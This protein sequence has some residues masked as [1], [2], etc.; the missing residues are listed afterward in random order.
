MRQNRAALGITCDCRAA[1]AASMAHEPQMSGD[2]RPH[3]HAL[4]LEK[5]V[6]KGSCKHSCAEGV[7][8]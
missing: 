6:R 7:Y 5:Q 2:W 8:V 1:H 4:Y 3:A